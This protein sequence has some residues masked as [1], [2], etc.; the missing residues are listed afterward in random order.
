MTDALLR[1]YAKPVPRY[2]SY[3]TAPHFSPAVDADVAA[4]WLAE[5]DPGASLSLYLHVP[6]CRAICTYCGCHTK[7]ARRDQP[8]DDY[9]ATLLA[10]IDTLARGTRARRVTHIHWGGGTPS[11]LGPERLLA[12]GERLA[13]RCDLSAVS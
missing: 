11:L 4:H 8:L 3:P 10:E 6:Y 2:T 5:L 12:L 7:A 1:R 13:L 9:T